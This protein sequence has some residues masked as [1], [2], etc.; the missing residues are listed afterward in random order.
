M[1]AAEGAVAATV[2]VVLVAAL[3]R[4]YRFAPWAPTRR[5][6]IAR[7]VRY[8][9]LA[10]G[11]CFV[12]LGCGDGRVLAALAAAAPDARVIG[13][14]RSLVLVG[15]ARLATAGT[16]NVQVVWGDLFSYDLSPADVVYCFGMPRALTG[17][18]RE[19]FLRELKPGARI[20][21]YAFAIPGLS[22]EVVHRDQAHELPLYSYR[23]T[24]MI[25]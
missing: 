18:V 20:I 5:R 4:A 21:S 10:R 19:K 7:V 13:V 16:R 14:E 12:E 3:W 25:R 22:D 6:D 1:T 15:I 17:A 8:A 2:I 24:G 9:A 11:E 23:V